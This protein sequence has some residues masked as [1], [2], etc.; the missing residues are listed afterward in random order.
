MKNEENIKELCQEQD[1]F[2]LDKLAE[3]LFGIKN[4]SQNADKI[5][6]YL[7]KENVISTGI[8]KKSHI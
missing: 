1:L 8:F 4:L 7:E 3:E 6:Q 5:K 2:I